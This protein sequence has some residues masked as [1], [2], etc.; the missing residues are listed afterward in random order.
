MNDE[1]KTAAGQ[2]RPSE[3]D[4]AVVGIGASAGGLRALTQ[5]LEHLPGEADLALVVILHLSPKHESSIGKLLQRFTRKPVIQM[6][7]PVRIERGTIYV[8]SPAVDLVM[9]DGWLKV[10]PAERPRGRHIAIDKFFRTLAAAHRDR[11]FGVILSGSGTDGSIGV[12]SLREHGGVTIAQLPEDAEYEDM[13]RSAIATGMVDF[14]LPVVE[15][16]QKILEMV[17]NARRITLPIGDGEIGLGL[18]ASQEATQKDEDALRD[19]L[20]ILHQ[21]TGHDFHHYKRATVLRRIERRLQ[22]TVTRDVHSYRDLLE[23]SREETPA[24]L[25]DLLISVTNFFRDR[26]AFEALERDIIPALV[27]GVQAPETIR[28]WAAGCATGEEAYSLAMLLS[29]EAG[30]KPDPPTVQVFATDIDDRAI[31][32]ARTA[33][34]PDSIVADVP[35][36]RLREFFV[37][38]KNQ[39]RIKKDL[40]DKVLFAAHNVLRDPPFSRMDLISCR[41]LLIYLDRSI[42]NR[43]LQMFHFALKPGGYLFLGSSESVDAAS[44]Y[45]DLVDKKHRI[46]RA[47]TSSQATVQV[48][49]L[50]LRAGP[51]NLPKMQPPRP[52]GQAAPDIH[53]RAL[54]EFSP[55]SVIVDFDYNVLHVSACAGSFLRFPGGAPSHN[56]LKVIDP[57]LRVE[58]RSALFQA[59][60]SGEEA[61]ASRVRLDKGPVQG[62]Y[63]LSVRPFRDGETDSDYLLVVFNKVGEDPIPRP[64]GATSSGAEQVIAHLEEELQRTRDSLQSTVEQS[65][66]S[67]EE[68]KASNEELQAINEELRSATEELETS[69]EELQSVNEELTTVNH[70]LK[71]KVEE[72]A[73]VN[74]DLR[75]FIASTEIATVFIDSEGRI[76]RYTPRAEDIFSIIPTDVGRR[77]LDI[78]HRLDYPELSED[79]DAAYQLLLPRQREVRALGGRLYMARVLPYRTGE[80][81]IDGAVLTFVDITALRQAEERAESHGWL[82]EQRASPGGGERWGVVLTDHRGNITGWSRGATTLLGFAAAD[83][84][85]R[86]LASLRAPQTAGTAGDARARRYQR[87]NGGFW[88]GCGT[89]VEL[90]AQHG[91]VEMLWEPA[92]RPA[93]QESPDEGRLASGAMV[94]GS[95]RDE[96]LAVMSHELKHP[97]NLIGINSEILARLPEVRHSADATRVVDTLRRAVRSQAKI[98]DDLLDLSRMRTGKLRLNLFPI[99]VSELVTTIVESARADST[100]FDLALELNADEPV[101]VCG[102]AQRIEQ[103]VWNLLS[104]AIKFTPAGGRIRVN[105]RRNGAMGEISV[106]DTGQGIDADFLP[107]VFDMF[108]QAAARAASKQTGLGIGLALVKQLVDGH[109]GCIE[110]ASG[111]LGQGSTFIV[112]LPLVK[113]EKPDTAPSG[114]Q[115]ADKPM[116]GLNILLVDDTRDTVEALQALLQFEGATVVTATSGE[117]ALALT[118]QHRFDL[119]LSDIGMPDMD[120]YAFISRFRS[121]PENAATPAIALSGFGSG[122]DVEA[123]LA[124]GFT[125]HICKPVSL[126]ALLDAIQELTAAERNPG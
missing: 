21:R 62:V 50:P 81:R 63:D 73:Q 33:V 29:E 74:D 120:G 71:L 66:T 13:P 46:F 58:L 55:P 16:P 44:P 41:N 72:A 90:E 22:V 79:I 101:I 23:N 98:I 75:N 49:A 85:G 113:E 121:K 109:S 24:L 103:I 40:R 97:L 17:E 18:G 47:R 86:P 28:A 2:S 105:V 25:G 91:A 36:Q 82:A 126:P 110:V 26:E 54:E 34:Y 64:I 10:T 70:E 94:S 37:H 4:F 77:L 27:A 108:G 119:L 53:R 8:I 5:F 80:N 78:T 7:E 57:A 118:D 56:L 92:A 61:V 19:I 93:E 43:L 68:L 65:E 39:Y 38:G 6:T 123:A 106:Q 122:R 52:V 35:P 87:R 15:I 31:V 67:T 125:R 30:R 96:F 9:E 84:L 111:G 117:Q 42:Q 112:C 51:A 100:A 95:L 99:N 20:R 124:A 1:Q 107:R 11:A 60:T 88:E 32:R 89:T 3:L 45:F 115:A 114:V 12:A 102:D 59:V 48:P 83:V 69:K 14:V 76:K 104:N 116:E